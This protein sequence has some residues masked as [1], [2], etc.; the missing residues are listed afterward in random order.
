MVRTEFTMFSIFIEL[1]PLPLLKVALMLS[2]SSKLMVT[3]LDD[4]MVN[5]HNV[6]TGA[7]NS[8]GNGTRLHHQVWLKRSPRSLSPMTSRPSCCSSSLPTPSV[9]AIGQEMLPPLFTEAREPLEAD[10]WLQVMESKFG[11]L[12]CTE[13]QNPL[14]R[15]ATMG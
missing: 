3:S 8:Q 1:S 11:L 6:W 7:K 15:V 10:H 5:T 4:R 13:V 2:L 9:V 12:R 14:H